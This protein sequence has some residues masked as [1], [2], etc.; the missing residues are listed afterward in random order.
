[1][2]GEI[3]GQKMSEYTDIDE[4]S[5]S[6]GEKA[7]YKEHAKITT[8]GKT[9][10]NDA[11]NSNY[12]VPLS[13]ITGSVLPEVGTDA[14]R[15]DVL[16]VSN[17]DEI[18]WATPSMPNLGK[19]L[20]YNQENDCIDFNPHG[21]GGLY[22]DSVSN[23]VSVK[24]GN[25]IKVDTTGVHIDTNGASDG[26]VLTYDATTQTVGWGAGGG[27]G[28]PDSSMLANAESA[29]HNKLSDDDSTFDV[30]EA[31]EMRFN[32]VPTIKNPDGTINT[33]KI[34]WYIKAGSGG[35]QTV[36]I[37]SGSFI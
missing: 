17:S 2:A 30:D 36:T 16:T 9:G 25:G 7:Y 15:G 4:S 22:V 33:Y 23:R 12:N 29:Y 24:D 11:V 32:F 13:E 8:F 28:L 10:D 5:L 19:G 6:A 14:H 21:S 35:F 26:N 31:Y 18:V 1:M 20:V 27:L 3:V 37:G 34:K